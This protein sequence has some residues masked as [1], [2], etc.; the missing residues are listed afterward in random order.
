M[1]EQKP[2]VGRTPASERLMQACRRAVAGE[3]SVLVVT[4]E[5]GMGKSALLT[6]LQEACAASLPELTVLRV[7]CRPPIGSF[8]VGGIQ[9]LQPFGHAIEQ[10]YLNSG[11][12]AKKRLALN[13]G[14]SVLASIPIAGDL[15]Y[16]VKAISQDVSEYKRETSAT[17]QKKRAAVTECIETLTAIAERQPYVLLVDDGQWSDSQSIEVLRMLIESVNHL[18]MVLIWCVTPSAAQRVNPS[19]TAL[20]HTPTIVDRT[21]ALTALTETESAAMIRDLVP[22]Q[23][24]PPAVISKLHDRSAGIPSIIV[25]YVKYLERTGDLGDDLAVNIGDHPNSDMAVSAVSEVDATVLSLCAAEGQEFT[26]FMLSALMNTDVL[27][28]IRECRR[29]Q[30]ETGLIRSLGMRTR[31]GNKTT[32]YEFTT[33]FAYTYF[34]H[35][36]EYEE[37]K[38]LHQRISDVLQREFNTTPHEEMRT[39]LAVFIAAH[40]AEAEDLGTTERMLAMSAEHAGTIGADDV[41]RHILRDLLPMYGVPMSDTDETHIADRVLNVGEGGEEA[42]ALG[43]GHRFSDSVRILSDMIVKGQAIEAAHQCTVILTQPSSSL[44]ASEECTLYCLAAR[45]YAEVEAWSDAEHAL[46]LAEQRSGNSARDRCTLLN[47]RATLQQRRGDLA[48]ARD[49]LFAAA[50]LAETL[51]TPSKVLTVSNI[52]LLLREMGDPTADKYERVVRTLTTELSWNALRAD[53]RLS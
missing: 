30:R 42:G 4:G 25:E 6:W 33:S 46:S 48:A 3:G 41:Q 8:H 17:Q 36:P 21:I 29:L 2:L 28:T 24:L 37:R 44:S 16:A 26:A 14:M 15:F 23:E 40:S 10:L 32:V 12:A 5:P 20:L 34:L 22:D 43:A 50:R 7:D 38:A 11:A 31:Y 18:P 13:I 27:T 1:A 19:L 52:V 9:P 51:P 45:A 39:Q 53:L 49:L 47:V 35:R